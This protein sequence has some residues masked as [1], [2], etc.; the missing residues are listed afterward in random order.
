M[1][2]C[3]GWCNTC[4]WDWKQTGARTS[5]LR[6]EGRH[7]VW[8]G[9]RRRRKL[10]TEEAVSLRGWWWNLNFNVEVRSCCFLWWV[11]LWE[12]R[13]LERVFW[14][15]RLVAKSAAGKGVTKLT[16]PLILS[17]RWRKYIQKR[18]IAYVYVRDEWPRAKKSKE[19]VDWTVEE[20]PPHLTV[21]LTI[22]TQPD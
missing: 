6:W 19:W 12:D 21:P 2:W 11:G 10:K 22:V 18:C 13:F 8:R 14:S 4:L 5:D 20:C 17:T 15:E 3:S 16:Q 9:G 7:K 1:V